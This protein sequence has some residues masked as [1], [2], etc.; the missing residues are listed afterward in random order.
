MGDSALYQAIGITVFGMGC[1]GLGYA[2]RA[3]ISLHRRTKAMRDRLVTLDDRTIRITPARE[4][5]KEEERQLGETSG[6]Q[7]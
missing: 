1:F 5:T 6:Q 4:L 3:V 2:V 7:R